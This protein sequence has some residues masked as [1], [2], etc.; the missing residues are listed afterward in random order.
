MLLTRRGDHGIQTIGNRDVSLETK[1]VRVD[2]S[3]EALIKDSS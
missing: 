1:S 2:D 3:V